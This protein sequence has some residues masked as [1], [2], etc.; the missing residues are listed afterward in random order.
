MSKRYDEGI[1][2]YKY[3]HENYSDG[4]KNI[5]SLFDEKA[6]DFLFHSADYS[7]YI[8]LPSNDKPS[9]EIIDYDN[10]HFLNSIPD[11]MIKSGYSD[12]LFNKHNSLIPRSNNDLLKS[13]F[14]FDGPS[15]QKV[16]FNTYLPNNNNKKNFSSYDIAYLTTFWSNRLAKLAKASVI[17]SIA[18][19]F[20]N[21][22]S[23]MNEY[24]INRIHNKGASIY[25]YINTKFNGNFNIDDIKNISIF[26]KDSKNFKAED[27]NDIKKYEAFRECLRKYNIPYAKSENLMHSMLL[28]QSIDNI[29]TIKNNA[30]KDLILK[31]RDNSKNRIYKSIDEN[32]EIAN[33]NSRYS[34]SYRLVICSNGMYS[35]LR[36]HTPANILDDFEKDNSLHIES[37]QKGS[38]IQE[39]SK[40]I[41]PINFKVSK[42]DLDTLVEYDKRYSG[43]NRSIN[44]FRKRIYPIKNEMKS[45]NAC[46]EHEE[47]LSYS[48]IREM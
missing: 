19:I 20:D 21:D 1:E 12:C 10:S 47:D 26:L 33:T 14:K 42:D 17:D 31:S 40:I 8:N 27:K 34:S 25:N 36:V 39:T 9:Q 45:E 15:S 5:Q 16:F 43:T 4:F 41:S 37:I 24:E 23:T 13:L 22:T 44:E 46:I 30:I 35:N 32:V 38:Q 48:N 6:D 2:T 29:Y 18:N 28:Y 3:I 7:E 11:F